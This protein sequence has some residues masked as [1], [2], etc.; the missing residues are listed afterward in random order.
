MRRLTI[1][2]NKA[3]SDRL[4]NAQNAIDAYSKSHPKKF[5]EAEHTEFR[6]LLNERA[7]ALSEATGMKIHSICDGHVENEEV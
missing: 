4:S 5:T 3:A 6:K 2:D 1:Q 7:S